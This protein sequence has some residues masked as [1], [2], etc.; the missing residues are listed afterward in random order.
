MPR[1]I[2][3]NDRLAHVDDDGLQRVPSAQEIYDAAFAPRGTTLQP[4]PID[5]LRD[6]RF[7]RV[8]AQPAVLLR[9]TLEEGIVAS[10]GVTA[11][12]GFRACADFLDHVIIDATWYPVD[13][14]DQKEMAEW[15]GN[16]GIVDGSRLT[17]GQI[18]RIRQATSE[19]FRVIDESTASL[20][21]RG[22]VPDAQDAGLNATLYPYQR[23]GV[24]FLKFVSSQEIGCLLADEMGLG[25]TLQ[26]IALLHA[27]INQ[28]RGPALVIAPST[29]LE[30]WRRE[31]AHFAPSIRTLVHSGKDRAGVTAILKA[32]QVVITSYETAT[33]DEPLL[34]QVMWDI[35]VLDEAQ[36]IK[37]PAANRTISIKQ[38]RRRISIAVS[39]TPVE[40]RL[41]DLWSIT[42]FCLPGLLGDLRTFRSGYG[43]TVTDAQALARIVSPVILRRR[44]EDV[45]TD[46][47]ALIEIPQAIDMGEELAVHYEQQ[48]IHS[49]NAGVPA[50]AALMPLRQLSAHPTLLRPWPHDLFD[51]VPKYARLVEIL[52]EV[53]LRGEKALVFASFQGVLDLMREDFSRRW[54]N[55][56]VNKIDGR[57]PVEDRQRSVDDF[58]VSGAGGVLLLN[59]KAA[60]T[61]LNI[62]AANHVIH[63]TPEWNPAVTQQATARAYRR[64][65]TRPVTVHHLFYANSVEEVMIDRMRAKKDLATAAVEG[66]DGDVPHTELLRALQ[67][68]PI[69]VARGTN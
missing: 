11:G 63:Y 41:E 31:L 8:P 12:K 45:A 46:L 27:R 44:V 4:N 69:T 38:L 50:I 6:I 40:N 37:N 16:H 53:I 30:N 58:S 66:H 34:E 24:S 59:P 68:S 57:T 35:L 14:A 61:G 20:G 5:G 9:G 55:A 42:D 13:T 62:T 64:K 33:R 7:S 49:L 2:I 47:P 15:M 28:G 10:L 36:A 39:G 51:S 23:S 25:K 22:M 26:I 65:Q 48:R 29:L 43:D 18:L 21:F 19:G 56:H 32:F 60:G 1:W 17:L 54:P 52:E 67:L 3:D